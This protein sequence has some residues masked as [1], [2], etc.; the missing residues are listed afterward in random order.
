MTLSAWAFSLVLATT[1]AAQPPL[2]YVGIDFR[3]MHGT[4][5]QKFL[6]VERVAPNGP[7][8]RAG[9]R[10]GDRITHIAGVPVDFGDELDFLIFIRDRKPNER[11]VMKITRGGKQVEA[12]IILGILPEA[13]RAAWEE[14]FRVAQQRRLAARGAK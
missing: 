2:P 6:H 11:L 12:V 13:A 3:W 7:A 5:Q 9:L 14:G 1:T 10:P 4:P 8:A